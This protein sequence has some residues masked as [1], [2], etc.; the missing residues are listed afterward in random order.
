MADPT[1]KTDTDGIPIL[2]DIVDPNEAEDSTPATASEPD[3]LDQAVIEHLLKDESIDQLLED[4]TA[5]LQSLV[6]WK[7]E[8][9]LKQD[10]QQV[11]HETAQRSGPKLAQDIRAQLRQ[12]LPGLLTQAIRRARG[13]P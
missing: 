2:E 9:F 13:E 7:I 8:E 11:I 10:I 1:I 6:T 3:L 5:D 4:M 12:A